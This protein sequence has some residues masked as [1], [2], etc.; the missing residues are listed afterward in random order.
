L[1]RS[2]KIKRAGRRWRN[3]EE[4]YLASV[5]KICHTIPAN[6]VLL[7]NAGCRSLIQKRIL[8]GMVEIV[9]VL[10]GI[11]G[12]GIICLLLSKHLFKGHKESDLPLTDTF[13]LLDTSA[14]EQIR[15][16]K[17]ELET[18]FDA[19]TDLICIIDRQYKII[20]VN[21]S[22][23]DFVGVPIRSLL[24]RSCYD[25]FWS[26]VG[27]CEQCPAERTFSTGEVVVKKM[28]LR[29]DSG[30]NQYYEINTYPVFDDFGKVIHVIE[31]IRNITEEKQM[32][33]QIIRSQKLV[34]IG[35]MTAGIAHEMNNPLSAISGM[36]VNLLQM[37]EKYGLNEK[38]VSRINE[39]LDLSSRANAVMKDLLHI[40]HN[41][42]GTSEMTNLNSLILS[43]IKAISTDDG[44]AIQQ[45]FNL[46]RTL[47]PIKCN[48]EKIEVVINNI[49]TNAFQAIQEKSKRFALENRSFN[50]LLLVSTQLYDVENIIIS[51]SDN[52]IGIP[53]DIRTLVFSPFFSTR[54]AGQC[55][56]MGLSISL[57]IVELHGGRIFFETIDE[58][59]IFSI[60]LPIERR[61][62]IE[63]M[64]L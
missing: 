44:C 62:S 50:G 11:L 58:M 39:I 36:A 48:N 32:T 37:P 40:S 16:S 57:K 4:L 38:G 60:I 24:G 56:G 3:K 7:F 41:S 15:I 31:F 46:E 27:T 49:V 20:R 14:S 2:F 55:R 17:R 59:T 28:E 12:T 22:Y 8:A 1:Q 18:V 64:Q 33:E 61:Y 13:E 42:D 34:S 54:P 6:C 43:T 5:A 47:P 26:K 30:L 29:R 63:K 53:D 10:L 9:P 51:I 35:I 45:K 25:V 21:K 23:A 19:I 52:G